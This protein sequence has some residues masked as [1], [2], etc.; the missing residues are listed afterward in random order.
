MSEL[1]NRIDAEAMRRNAGKATRLLKSIANESRLM[2]LCSLAEGEHSVSELNR[3]VELSQSALSQ[4]LAILREEGLVSTRRKAQSIYY[5]L[6]DGDAMDLI[7]TLH[8]I[9]CNPD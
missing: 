6:S 5:S 1:L 4:H 3:R 7:E 9:F 8:D 2:I